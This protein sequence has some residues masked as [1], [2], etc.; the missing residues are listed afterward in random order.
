MRTGKAHPVVKE[1]DMVKKVLLTITRARAG[2]AC[3]V[4][5]RGRL[6]GIFTDGDLRRNVEKDPGILRRRVSQVMTK[7]PKTLPAGHLAV[8]A[9]KLLRSYRIDEIPVVDSR[10]RP[11]GLLD[12]QDL[13]KAGL[14]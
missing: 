8:E 1:S 4:D 11:V 2:S 9:L 10:R 14:V 3:V 13:L 7:N 5:G 12:I 6:A